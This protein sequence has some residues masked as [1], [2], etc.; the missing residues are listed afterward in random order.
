MKFF[1]FLFFFCNF[2]VSAQ[3]IF[4]FVKEGDLKN[5][6]KVLQNK[7]ANVNT[8]NESGYTPLMFAAYYN[9]LEV[10]QFLLEKGAEINLESKYGT[11]LMAAT[12]KG[13]RDA[14]VFLIAEGATLNNKDSYGNTALLHSAVFNRTEIAKLLLEAGADPHIK[15][16]RGNKA[17][18]YVILKQ[19][20]DF[21][22]LLNSYR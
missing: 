19:N 16:V 6:S 11:A 10:I 18:D 13:H 15:D 7:T 2:G 14:V 5:I 17:L 20:I 4:S 9:Q 1:L 22:K 21:I 8:I 3:D 12:I